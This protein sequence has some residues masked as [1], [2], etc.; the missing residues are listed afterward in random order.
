MPRTIWPSTRG[1]WSNHADAL[2]ARRHR[3]RPRAAAGVAVADEVNTP[4]ASCFAHP[5]RW[6][7]DRAKEPLAA[8][9]QRF[10]D[11]MKACDATFGAAVIEA[12]R[13]A[14]Q[15]DEHDKFMRQSTYVIAA[16]AIIWAVVAGAALTLY[17][18]QRRLLRELAD[19]EARLKA[20]GTSA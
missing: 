4:P 10:L 8:P 7:Y 18:R 6:T 12:V 2:P 9:G 1:S 17:L 14:I 16:Y 20:A 13:Y 15:K 19:L 11:D 5:D 3:H